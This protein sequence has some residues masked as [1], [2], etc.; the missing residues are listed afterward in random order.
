[1]FLDALARIHAGEH[2]L[3]EDVI[4]QLLARRT[5]DDRLAALSPR[6]REV[7]GLMA[8]GCSNAE[9]AAQLFVSNGAVEKYSAQIFQKLDL[10]TDRA[11]NRRVQAVLTYLEVEARQP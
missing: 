8:Q 4:A 9:I 10:S 2:V 11:G 1:M 5:N 6:E 7:L 3:D